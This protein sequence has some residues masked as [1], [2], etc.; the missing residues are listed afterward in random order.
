MN[1]D[2]LPAGDAILRRFAALD[3][4]AVSD[5]LDA[6]GLPPGFGDLTP[7]WGAPRV[8]GYAAT[9]QLEPWRPG[10]S[11]AHL[12]AHTV[13]EADSETVVVV[14]NDGRVDVSCWGGLLSLGATLRGVRGV[15]ADGVC[16]DVGEAAELGFP[17]FSRG[18]TPRTA[19]VRLQEAHR[20]RPVLVAG[21]LVD[22]GDVI[23]ADSTGVAVVP[24]RHAEEVLARAERVAARERSIAAQLR[25]GVALSEA[26]RDERLAAAAGDVGAGDQSRRRAAAEV[27]GDER[28]RQGLAALPTA[29]LSDALD[30]LGLLGSLSGISPLRDG[31]RVVGPAV[32]VAYE[33]V[34]PAHPGTVGDFLDDVPAGAVVVVDNGGRTDC[35]VWGGIMTR[36][37][38]ARGIAGAVLHGTCR[39]VPSI[40]AVGFPMWCTA[41]F[42]R[43][44]KDRVQLKAVQAPLHIDGVTIRPGDWACADDDGVV[45][46]PADRAVEVVEVALGIEAAE[47]D[48]ASAVLAGATL[49]QAREDHGYH[50]L[51]SARRAVTG[52]RQR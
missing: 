5:A 28:T 4:T 46:V 41:R 23:V 1:P 43:T 45:I 29:S 48:I 21:V 35:T 24:R 13:A 12:N 49:T 34:D 7:T 33:P 32:T 30:R 10:P 16:R 20:G 9:V 14:A 31:Q 25:S 37:A 11:G 6:L 51:Q 42:M 50:V 17:V 44:G 39:D 52:E 47:A 8:V 3:P 22:Q 27:T 26:M 19:R 36:A 40:L 38:A 15:V 18:V 2:H